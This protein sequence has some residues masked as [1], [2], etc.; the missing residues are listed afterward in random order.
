MSLVELPYAFLLV[1]MYSPL[2]ALLTDD[3]VKEESEE[4]DTETTRNLCE[5]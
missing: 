5:K 4:V 2:S 1:H 3:M